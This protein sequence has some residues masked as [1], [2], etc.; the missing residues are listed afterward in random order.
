MWQERGMVESLP[1]FLSI[2]KYCHSSVRLSVRRQGEREKGTECVRRR[3]GKVGR[4]RL[5]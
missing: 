1:S 3:E 5:E 4:M 2:L